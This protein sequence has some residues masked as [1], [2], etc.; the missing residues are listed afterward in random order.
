MFVGKWK[1]CKNYISDVLKC[2]MQAQNV[3]VCVCVFMYVYVYECV[4]VCVCLCVCMCMFMFMCMCM[5][6]YVYIHLC[7][8]MFM[9]VCMFIFISRKCTFS[10]YVFTFFHFSSHILIF[11]LLVFKPIN[12]CYFRHFHQS[13]DRNS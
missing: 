3:C 6:V 2:L 12:V 4:C 10:S 11:P 9:Y 1:Q 13:T 7:L 8:C 5:C